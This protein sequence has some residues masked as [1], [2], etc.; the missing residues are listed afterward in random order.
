MYE[1]LKGKEEL[2][3]FYHS[4]LYLKEWKNGDS[5]LQKFWLSYIDMVEILLNTLYACRAD[6]WNLLLECIQK[7][8]PYAFAYDHINYTR[9]LSIMLGDMLALEE[10]YSRCLQR[11]CF[12]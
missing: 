6:K 3:S 4:F 2:Q 11:I 9:Y 5:G 7:I 8:I 10:D 12:W 1:D